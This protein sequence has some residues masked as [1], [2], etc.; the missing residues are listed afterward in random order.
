VAL[1][2]LVDSGFLVTLSDGRYLASLVV[3]EDR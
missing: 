3:V 2:G 1:G